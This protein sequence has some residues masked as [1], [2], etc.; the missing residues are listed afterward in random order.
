LE[1]FSREQIKLW[2][3]DKKCKKPPGQKQKDFI[4]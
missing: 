2:N 3:K 4:L 1:V